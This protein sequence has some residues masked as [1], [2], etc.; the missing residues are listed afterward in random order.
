MTFLEEELLFGLTIYPQPEQKC[1]SNCQ[2]VLS[3]AARDSSFKRRARSYEWKKVG[4]SARA[5]GSRRP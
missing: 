5:A 2:F 3:C 4:E 1:G